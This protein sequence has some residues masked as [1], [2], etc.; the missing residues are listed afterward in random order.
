MT[1]TE[2]MA[3]ETARY[4]DAGMDLAAA[5]SLA[6]ADWNWCGGKTCQMRVADA[7]ERVLQRHIQKKYAPTA[8]DEDETIRRWDDNTPE[9]NRWW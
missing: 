4:I 6:A 3:V 7:L 2:F 1:K 5:R 8:A 9:A